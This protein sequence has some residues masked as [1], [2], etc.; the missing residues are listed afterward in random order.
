MTDTIEMKPRTVEKP[1]AD[2]FNAAVNNDVDELII[3]LNKGQLLSSSR[4][5][6]AHMNP[7]HIACI[8]GSLDFIVEASKHHSFDPFSRDDNLRTPF[9]HASAHCNFDI[10]KIL[11]EKMYPRLPGQRPETP[12]P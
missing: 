9:D 8:E 4:P 5:E 7:V 10:M 1:K 12:L 6:I 11:Y 3:A 2:I